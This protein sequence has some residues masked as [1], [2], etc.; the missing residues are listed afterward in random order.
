MTD[1]NEELMNLVKIFNNNLI[2]YNSKQQKTALK[3]ARADL[4][5]LKKMCD[6]LRKQL[7]LE[8]KE[9]PVRGRTKKEEPGVG[10]PKEE[11]PTPPKEEK[12]KEK[13]K[14]KKTPPKKKKKE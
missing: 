10:A 4:L 11:K 2:V 9:M 5:S 14:K 13:P 3:R 1:M 12:P 7:A 8:L 6:V